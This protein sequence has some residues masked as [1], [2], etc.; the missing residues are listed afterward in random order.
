MDIKELHSFKLGDAVKFH[1][2]LNPKL[3]RGNRLDPAVKNQL[4]NIAKD[5]LTELGIGDVQVKDI[6]ISGS[7]AAYT[8]TPNSDLDLHIVVDYNQFNNDTVYR[9]LFN[10]KKNLYNDSHNITIRGIPVEVYMEDSSEPVVS[11]GEYSLL[12]DKWNQ[13]VSKIKRFCFKSIKRKRQ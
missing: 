10:A 12:K 1:N 13:K 4:I 11:V 3:F 9:E 8:Y 6:T 7:N 2:E 5:F